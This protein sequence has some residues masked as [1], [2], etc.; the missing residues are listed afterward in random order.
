VGRSPKSSLVRWF[1]SPPCHHNT[2]AQLQL[3]FMFKPPNQK[4]I[5]A[6]KDVLSNK[7]T[8]QA[9]AGKGKGKEM[10][11]RVSNV[12]RD[13]LRRK[14]FCSFLP[15]SSQRFAFCELFARHISPTISRG[16]NG[17]PLKFDPLIYGPFIFCGISLVQASESENIQ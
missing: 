14:P 9:P 5:R 15:H 10:S 7:T 4:R 6:G 11:G 2:K 16:R 12:G 13:N 17:S 1:S 8:A 3:F